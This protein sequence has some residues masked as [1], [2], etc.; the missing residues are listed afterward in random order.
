MHTHTYGKYLK[1]PPSEIWRVRHHR[2]RSAL[3]SL[4]HIAWARAYARTLLS[5]YVNILHIHEGKREMK[6]ERREEKETCA[7]APP[8]DYVEPTYLHTSAEEAPTRSYQ[9]RRTR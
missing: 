9:Y 6:R 2:S 7:K 8:R 5:T 3:R 1:V 4:V